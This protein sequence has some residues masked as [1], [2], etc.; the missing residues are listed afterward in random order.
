MKFVLATLGT[1]GDIEPCAA[2][3]RELQRRGHRVL[4]AVP[5]NYIGFVESA[6]L[7]AVAHGRNQVQQNADIVR[8]YGTTPPP[9]L[10]A[11]EILSDIK[12]LWPRLGTA[13][14]SLAEDADLL[15]TDAGEQGLA[16]NVAEHY[17]IP[18]AAVHIYPIPPGHTGSSITKEAEDAQRRALGLPESTPSTRRPLEIQAYDELFFP[19]LA[20]EWVECGAQRPFVGGLTLELPTEVDDDVSSWIA[21]GTPPIYFGFGSSARVASPT[22]VIGMIT[23]ACAELGERAL[24]C[25]GVS[26]LTAQGDSVD[27]KVVGAVNHAA[28][29]PAC[30]AVVHHGG[31]GTTFA[32]I[33]AGVPTLALAVSVDQPMWASAVNE[34]GVGIG[35]RFLETTLES[36]VADLRSILTPPYVTR[37]REV[38][39]QMTP[40]A[41]SAATAAQAL[42]D[43]ATRGPLA[44]QGTPRDAD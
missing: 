6:G 40:P 18:Q 31:P 34:L 33:R 2:I 38:A 29:F 41:Q 22:D 20:A 39:A 10:M 4:M 25:S 19:G 13:L 12:Q 9:V 30:R 44:D 36:L 28:V 1:R 42:E 27:V 26:D 5:P 17:G 35:R 3:G 23:A 8:K 7:T 16:A 11:W 21:A 32:G 24:I 43:A 15:L 37:T 14:V